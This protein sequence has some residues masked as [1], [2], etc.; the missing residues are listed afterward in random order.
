MVR[1]YLGSNA[2]ETSVDT[3]SSSRN[4]PVLIVFPS[5]LPLCALILSTKFTTSNSHSGGV[6]PQPSFSSR[7]AQ[8]GKYLQ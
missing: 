1:R 8:S 5:L 7:R 6:G 4:Y 2:Q 3:Q